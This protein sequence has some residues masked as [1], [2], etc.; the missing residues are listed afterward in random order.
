M[1]PPPD[2][3]LEALLDRELKQLPPLRAPQTLMPRVLAALRVQARPWHQR[4]WLTWPRPWQALSAAALFA[5]LAGAGWFLPGIT[6][7]GFT[8]ASQLGQQLLA[9]LGGWADSLG[10]VVNAGFVVWRALMQP[11]LVYALAF[12]ALLFAMSIGV[13]SAF[14]RLTWKQT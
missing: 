2:P 12:A 5:L 10:T 8:H 4:P 11:F 14:Y 7:N 9:T 13:G 1:N 3:R 6:A